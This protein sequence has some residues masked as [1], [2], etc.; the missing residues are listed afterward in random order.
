MLSY[1]LIAPSSYFP[2]FSRKILDIAY[3]CLNNLTKEE[4]EAWSPIAN[5][6]ICDCYIDL[7]SR[8]VQ[9]KV[10]SQRVFFENI[11]SINPQI[12]RPSPDIISFDDSVQL[13]WGK[14]GL[15]AHDLAFLKF[16]EKNTVKHLEFI[17]ESIAN[18]ARS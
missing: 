11:F 5:S 8:L 1:K 17:S 18:K 13:C 4:Q 10:S 3:L 2:I 7:I 12:R 6:F 14:Y 15:D 16:S 9:S